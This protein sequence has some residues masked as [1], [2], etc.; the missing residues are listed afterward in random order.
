M[1]VPLLL[2]VALAVASV[3]STATRAEPAAAAA[4]EPAVAGERGGADARTPVEIE[5]ETPG[6]GA[7]VE[8]KM[9]MAEVRGR[10]VAGGDGPRGFDVMLVIDVSRSTEIASGADVDGDGEVGEGMRS[11]DPEDTILHAEARAALS[12]LE[13]LD[14]AHVR[15]GLITFSGA[16]DPENGLRT[17]P[18]SQDATLRVPLTEDYS[19]LRRGLDAM[20]ARGPHGATNFAAGIRLATRELAGMGTA[21][22]RPRPGFRKVILFLTDGVPS[23]PAGRADVSD[24]GDLEAAVRAAQVAQAAGIRINS[25]ALGTNALTRPKGATEIARVTLGTFTPVVEPGSIVAAL[26]SVS[27]ANVEDVGVVNVSTREQAPD[28]RL[29]PD[30]SFLAFVPVRVGRNRVIVSA[31]A[32]DGTETTR[33]LVFD[34]ALKEADDLEKRRELE[35]LRRMTDELKRYQLAREIERERLRRERMKR[36]LEIQVERE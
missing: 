8:S 28:V 11:T 12:L 16:A 20:L 10:A 31:L 2:L 18:E 35:R 29:N 22:S 34:F 33:E 3:P 24:P 25:F 15:V 17:A 7:R 4:L 13:G 26:Q 6:P 5:I 23:F 19:Q 30:G 32:S 27:F 1:R 36:V 9:H 21:R 14:P